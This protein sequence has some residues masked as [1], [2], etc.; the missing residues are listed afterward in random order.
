MG[1][2]YQR[3][4]DIVVS[5]APHVP[6]CF[7]SLVPSTVALCVT[8]AAAA[9]AMNS[10]STTHDSSSTTHVVHY[11]NKACVECQVCLELVPRHNMVTLQ[12]CDS[13]HGDIVCEPCMGH[14]LRGC[15]FGTVMV[16]WPACPVADCGAAVDYADA[17]HFIVAGLSNLN[18]R[19]L[20]RRRFDR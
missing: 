4:G 14:H 8:M 11:D 10:S 18:D 7:H 13:R 19:K 5:T 1:T 15:M 12:A 2:Y 9:A 6:S 17:R 16:D 20:S 3:A